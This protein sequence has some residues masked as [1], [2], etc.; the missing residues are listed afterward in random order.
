M[1]KIFFEYTFIM[2]QEHAK[3]PP[4]ERCIPQLEKH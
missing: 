4:K 3:I 2:L 1:V